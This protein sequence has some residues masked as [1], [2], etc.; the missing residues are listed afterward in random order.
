MAS[1]VILSGTALGLFAFF[2]AAIRRLLRLDLLLARLPM[3]KQVQHAVEVMAIYRQRPGLILWAILITFPVHTTVVVSTMLAGKALGLPLSPV[4]Y[5]V[6]VPVVVL[7]GAIPIS[8]QG[9]GVME[10]FAIL[11]T[12]QQ[13][14]TIGQ[15][16]ALTMSIRVVQIH[17]EP[18]RRN[19]RPP[20]RLSRPR[21]RGTAGDGGRSRGR[22]TG[23]R[24]R[25][26]RAPGSAGPGHRGEIL[27]RR[28]INQ[29]AGSAWCLVLHQV[30]HMRR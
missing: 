21:G 27:T 7:V 13:G 3:Q 4:Y 9:A 19:L 5:F 26:K 30:C 12:R 22:R 25:R 16:F 6:V 15:A 28:Q 8:P 18:Q 29:D 24:R 11:L 10:F 17:V 20:R 23:G 2:H 14:A 1:L